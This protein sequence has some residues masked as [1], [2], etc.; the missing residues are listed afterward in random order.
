MTLSFWHPISLFQSQHE[1][2]FHS[3]RRKKKVGQ[4]AHNVDVYY[5][6]EWM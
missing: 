1:L 3:Y 4:H 2:Q 5:K 6:I